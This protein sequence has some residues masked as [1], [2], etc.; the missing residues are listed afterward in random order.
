[1]GLINHLGQIEKKIGYTFSDKSLLS[2][3]FIHRSYVN[4]DRDFGKQHNERLEFLGDSVLNLLVTE[5]LY[6]NLPDV[7]EGELSFLRSR[8]VDAQSC[9]EYVKK[10]D[11]AQF[12]LLGKG[13][14]LSSGRGRL[15]ILSDLFEAVVG[16]MYLDGGLEPVRLFLFTHFEKD[17]K[18]ILSTP[19]NN[20]KAIL[21]DYA[22]RV[23]HVT[24]E[25]VVNSE[26]GPDHQKTFEVIVNIQNQELGRGVGKSKKEAQQAAAQMAVEKISDQPK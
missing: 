23:Y 6:K 4:E 12:L 5:Y 11:I 19:M 20:W 25:Y 7:P 14:R 22:Q 1:M 2:L 8:L 15:S 3:A 26:S 9:M 21:Q 10:L 17:I 16:A 18:N 13:E 24:P